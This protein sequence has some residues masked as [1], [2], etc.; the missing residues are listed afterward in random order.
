MSPYGSTRVDGEGPTPCDLMF[1]GEGPGADEDKWG[2]P[3]VG[4]SGRELNRYVWNSCQRTRTSVYVTNLVKY[5]VPNDGD[6]T[7]DDIKRDEGILR[8]EIARVHPQVIVAVGR[9]SARWFLGGVDMDWAHGQPH[10]SSDYACVVVPVVHPAAGLHSTE[11]Q[12]TIAWDFEQLG[13][14]LRGEDVQWAGEDAVS[15][16]DYVLLT[17]H[18]GIVPG[19]AAVDTEGSIA[20]PWCATWSQTPGTAGCM[21][22]G[23]L[24]FQ[25]V[26]LHNALHDI[27]VLRSMKAEYESFDDTMIMAYL[28]CVEPQ[29]LKSLAKR[30]CGMS[31]SSYDEIV[32]DASRRLATKWLR[33]ASTTLQETEDG[34]RQTGRNT[35]RGTKGGVRANAKK[36]SEC[37]AASAGAAGKRTCGS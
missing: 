24:D 15:V 34:G 27:G 33:H 2:R 32:G 4:K 17:R 31:M 1:V 20:K 7:P 14:L 23:K 16:T 21:R 11:F 25:H 5:R 29:G 3:F 12:G 37:T 6:P 28:L 9:W 13:R 10:W 22:Q 19:L 8:D 26:V 18:N 36:R 30:H 35:T